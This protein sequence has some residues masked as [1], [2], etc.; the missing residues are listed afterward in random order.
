MQIWEGDEWKAAFKTNC[1]LYKPTVMFFGL[2]NTPATFQV[3]INHIFKELINKELIL[4]YLDDLM[5]FSED[6]DQHESM[7]KRV[8]KILRK[9][10][11]YLKPEKCEF[12]VKS[13]TFLEHVLGNRE[14]NMDP[15]KSSM[16]AAWPIL[17]D[18]K[19]LRQFLSMGN[20]L[21]RF[22]LRYSKIIRPL[23]KLTGNA[24]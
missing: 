13:V 21:R 4:L 16:V 3:F 10:R 23:T 17:S 11:L 7:T 19:E 9:N 15:K 1:G 6:D 20:W 24:L 18:K 14:L 2:C 5:I 12:D 22:V 8:F